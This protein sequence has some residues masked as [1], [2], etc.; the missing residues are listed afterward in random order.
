[1]TVYNS[2]YI[3]TLIMDITRSSS[4]KVHSFHNNCWFYQYTKVQ[5]YDKAIIEKKPLTCMSSS[6]VYVVWSLIFLP[7]V[8]EVKH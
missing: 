8:R 2:V 5:C 3:C 1:M 6:H 7:N 4:I